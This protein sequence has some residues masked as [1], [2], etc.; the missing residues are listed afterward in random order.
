MSAF[1]DNLVEVIGT[2]P[3]DDPVEALRDA[4]SD[5]LKGMIAQGCGPHHLKSMQWHVQDLARFHPGRFEIEL[6]YREVFVGFC[7]PVTLVQSQ[8]SGLRAVA[9]AQK[10]ALPPSDVPVYADY[11]LS[12]LARQYSP[13]GQADMNVVFKSWSRDG[14]AMR[15]RH[16]GLDIAYGPARFQ[17]FDLFKPAKIERPPVWVFLHGGY[18]QASDKLQH[19]QF[20]QGMLA[21]GFAVALPNYGLAPER[22]LSGIVEDVSKFMGFLQDE[23]DNLGLDGTRIHVAGHSAGGHL[24][25]IMAVRHAS[26]SLRS[27]LLLSGLFDLAPISLLPFG[28]LLGLNDDNVRTLS[29]IHFAPPADMAVGLAVGHM[30]SDEFKRQSQEMACAWDAP[31][32]LHAPGH[33]FSMLE[34]LNGGALLDLA[35]STASD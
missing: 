4:L 10:P 25:A 6:A 9:H 11:S 35:L 24:A 1:E 13:R 19:A 27:V 30:E 23:A 32:V 16:T 15:A 12:T 18:W 22:S 33:H 21:A 8:A 26:H 31:A 2:S 17:T 5:V 28:R 29:P 7:V 34:G 20:A 14:S 3:S